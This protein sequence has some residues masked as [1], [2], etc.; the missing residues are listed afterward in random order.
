MDVLLLMVGLEAKKLIMKEP[1]LVDAVL[2]GNNS[3]PDISFAAV[4]GGD[5][6]RFVKLFDKFNNSAKRCNKS[7]LRLEI[8]PIV[9]LVGKIKRQP[10]DDLK[11]K[12]LEKEGV[13]EY[14]VFAGYLKHNGTLFEKMGATYEPAKCEKGLRQTVIS[15][16]RKSC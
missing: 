9:V 1:L 4:L 16:L 12:V 6:S 10:Y 13:I 8:A 14:W 2:G 15:A 11:I 3:N 5:D 7:H